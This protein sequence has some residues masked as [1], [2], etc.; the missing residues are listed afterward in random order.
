[1]VKARVFLATIIVDPS[2]SLEAVQK[3]VIGAIATYFPEG[4]VR[5]K[6]A[7]DV[8]GADWMAEAFADR[9]VERAN[10]HGC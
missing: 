7:E 4:V 1:M 9:D 2:T 8:L 3:V 5:V 6:T 10:R